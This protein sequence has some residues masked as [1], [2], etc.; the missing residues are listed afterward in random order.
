M[1]KVGAMGDVTLPL[2][3]DDYRSRVTM[4][5]SASTMPEALEQEP[6]DTVE[7]AQ[8]FALPASVNGRLFVEGNADAADADHFAL[9]L[10]KGQQ[11]VLETRAAMMGS[12]ADTK[13][14]VLDAKGAPVPMMKLQATKDSSIT[15]RS[16]DANDPAI[17][18]YQFAEMD[19]NDYMYFN[20]EVLKI[21]R[22]ARGPDADMVYY[23]NG[24]KRRAYFNTSPAGH[25]LDDACYVVEPKRL[26]ERIAPNGLPVFTLH[27]TNDDDGERILGSDS[28]LLFT[29]PDAGRF[30]VRVSDTRGWSGPRF[31]YRLIA[32]APEPDFS[33][34]L[35]AKNVKT[36]P[37]NSG[38]E[39]SVKVTRNDGWDGD[40]RVDISDVP[41][42]FFVSTP[43]V[44]Q[45]GH[46]GAAG[47]VFAHAN[48]KPS[49]HDL[50]KMKVTA[51]A[52]V[53]G[54]EVK[55]ALTGFATVTVTAPAK[56]SLFMEPDIA[57]KAAGDG[58]SAPAKP[59]EITIAP[60]TTVP[61]WLR[62][63]RR[64]DDALIGLDVENLPH[65]VI[66]DNIGLNG[67]QIRAG[68]NEREIFLTC[69][70]W[71]QEQDRLCHVVVGSARN[72]AVRDDAAQTGFPVL[73]KVRKP[74]PVAAK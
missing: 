64:G 8:T 26:D 37:V 19:L 7:K 32:R 41:E 49:A 71:V 6:N 1:V 38:A 72:D 30:I 61:A 53:N 54:K 9:S 24:G 31:A 3:S 43:V 14:E 73:L 57:G 50:S 2:D 56:K 36:I 67:V 16:E 45:A 63:D 52:T 48:T 46:L 65:G 55:K 70:K 40:V 18:L 59:Y 4:K 12:P 28:R 5:V 20:G 10:A 23:A 25:G 27:Y 11:I 51:T 35:L 42:G 62:V 15:L 47:S 68:E 13:I 21:F 60:G 34:Q 69:A 17:R 74:A 66:V 39:F 33:A 44:V 29:A 22:L 58:R